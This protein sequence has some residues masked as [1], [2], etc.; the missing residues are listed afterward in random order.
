MFVV[1]PG[2]RDRILP[3]P[4]ERGMGWGSSSSGTSSSSGCALGIV[5]AVRVRHAGELG[6]GYDHRAQAHQVR[7]AG[8]ARIRRVV[9]RPAHPGHMAALAANAQVAAYDG[10]PMKLVMTVL[11]RNE[12]DV[13]DAQLA[14][15]L[16]AG[17]DFVVATDNRSDDGTTEILERY[18]RAGVLHLVHEPADDMRQ[19]EWVT[20]MA[21]L[22]ATE[23]EADWVIESD[24]DEFWWPRGG[25][26][27]DVLAT[28]P[29]RFGLVRG[30]WRHF[31]P[32]PEDGAPFSERMIVRLAAPAPPDDKRTIFHAHQK[33]AHRAVADVEIEFGNPMRG[34]GLV[35]LQAGTRSRCFHFSIRSAA[36]LR[37]KAQGGHLRNPSYQPVT[38]DLRLHEA[39][40][41]ERLDQ[42]LRRSWST[43]RRAAAG[44]PMEPWRSTS[45]PRRATRSARGARVP[46]AAGDVAHS[47]LSAPSVSDDARFAGEISALVD[48][49]AIVRAEQRTEAFEQRMAVTEA[50]RSPERAVHWRG[51]EARH[52]PPRPGRGGR[53]R[54]PGSRSI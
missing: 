44:S 30:C 18:E 48:I 47:R 16:H 14:F 50:G 41:H 6:E 52:D 39:R 22:A 27:K 20:R 37:R 13:I 36:Q 17:V 34:R 35:P 33:V 29:E 31:V 9:G 5:D 42:L 43:R 8:Q 12:A 53:D 7:G 1:G 45:T 15:H 23:F 19:D 40:R 24:A 26:L 49:D 10:G 46:I 2:C 4:Q 54:G 28:V 3:F 11:A 21:R 38:H 25:S 51:H 32:L